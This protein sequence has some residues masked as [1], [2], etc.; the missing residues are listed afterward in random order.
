MRNKFRV[1]RSLFK[2]L[3]GLDPQFKGRPKDRT[4][5][6]VEGSHHAASNV[7][8]HDHH[9]I[10]I[11]TVSEL[12][13][14]PSMVE[15]DVY[16]F[17]PKTFELGSYGKT[18]LIKDFRSRIRLALPVDGEQGAAAFEEALTSLSDRL[19]MLAGAELAGENVGDLNHTICKNVLDAA[20]DVAAVLSETLK[21]RTL[22]HT[23]SILLCHSL[24]TTSNSTLVGLEQLKEDIA[25]TARLMDKFRLAIV[26]KVSS[27]KAILTFLDEYMS[28]T[29]VQYL[30]VIRLELAKF[31]KIEVQKAADSEFSYRMLKQ[32]L[33]AQL[34]TQ[35]ESE[36]RHRTHLGI[37]SRGNEGELERE[38]RLV[39]LSHLKKFF[40][41][42]TFIDVTRQQAA[43]KITESAATF[44]TAMAAAIAATIEFYGRT[45]IG[46]LAVKS[47]LVL[48]FGIL[49]YVLRDR[50]KDKAK[51]LFQKKALQYFPDFEQT[52]IANEHTIGKVREWFSIRK[53]KEVSPEIMDLR[54]SS[55]ITE[56]ERRL[57]EEVFHC[58]KIQEVDAAELLESGRLVY[59]RALYENT[60]INIERHLK[61]MDDAFKELTDLDPDGQFLLTRSHRVYYFYLCVKTMIG[62]LDRSMSGS[63]KSLKWRQG[64]RDVRN[65]Q[66][67]L[68]RIVLDKHGVVRIEDLNS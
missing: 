44:A 18:E 66:T 25:S 6:R 42:S 15:T 19:E 21:H 10:E 64:L 54:L 60:R 24:L 9:N 16:L 33:E 1:I 46:S 39:R 56:L 28:Q 52:L 65:S 27:V 51:A 20:K 49:V 47:L 2:P 35:Q 23:R 45:A 30:S 8:L 55:G 50:L 37:N 59:N 67:L 26:S 17:V 14:E 36:A 48:C 43:V 29:Y 34:N 5:S 22:E 31:E 11:K 41:S 4:T 53:S 12:I 38:Q 63:L 68:Y 13:S 32:K 40:Q 62:P 58:H 7:T 3:P 57:P 61:H